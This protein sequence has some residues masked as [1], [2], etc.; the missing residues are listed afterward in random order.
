MFYIF[1]GN[2][3]LLLNFKLIHADTFSLLSF[4]NKTKAVQ[5]RS[6]ANFRIHYELYKNDNLMIDAFH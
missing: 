4:S 6:F 1:I 5:N 3:C 2:R